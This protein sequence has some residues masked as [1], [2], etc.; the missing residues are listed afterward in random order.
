MHWGAAHTSKVTLKISPTA[1]CSHCSRLSG[2]AIL[3]FVARGVGIGS[4]SATRFALGGGMSFWTGFGLGGGVAGALDG[5]DEGP[6]DA[7]AAD[8]SFA[9][10]FK[11][12]CTA[13]SD[14]NSSPIYVTYALSI[15]QRG[16]WIIGHRENNGGRKE[17]RRRTKTVDAMGNA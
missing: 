7:D 9:R 11:R 1:L 12:I 6:G 14:L 4:G 16:T 15:I 3:T 13:L 5:W 10:R 2:G 8:C 17:R